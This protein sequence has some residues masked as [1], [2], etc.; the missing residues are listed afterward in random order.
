MGL[1]ILLLTNTVHIYLRLYAFLLLYNYSY[2]APPPT[3]SNKSFYMPVCGLLKFVCCAQSRIPE[4]WW[5]RRH[6][7]INDMAWSCCWSVFNRQ[8]KDEQNKWGTS[9]SWGIVPE[10][11]EHDLFSAVKHFVHLP[12]DVNAAVVYILRSFKRLCSDGSVSLREKMK[13]VKRHCLETNAVDF[14]HKPYKVMA[15]SRI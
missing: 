1:D 4:W 15:N 12:P 8:L 9:I 10:M 7:M 11:A 5:Y 6:S 2:R 14:D 13:C 3:L